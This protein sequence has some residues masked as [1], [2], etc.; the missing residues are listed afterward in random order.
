[1]A[2]RFHITAK[3][4]LEFRRRIADHESR[5]AILIR[6]LVHEKRPIDTSGLYNFV[7]PYGSSQYVAVME[8]EG[9]R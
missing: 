6:E 8:K 3:N 4:E 9:R 5:G 7:G 1:M 2:F